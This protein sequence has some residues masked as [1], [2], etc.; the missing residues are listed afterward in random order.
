[1]PAEQVTVEA[2]DGPCFSYVLTPDSG[3]RHP[4]VIMYSD[5]AGMRI[6][7]TEMA[8]QLANAGFIVLVPDPFYRFGPYG[9][10]VPKELFAGDFMAVIGPLMATTGPDKAAADTTS[11]IAYLDTRDDIE[12]KKIGAIGFCMGGG[13][14]IASAGAHPDRIAA[15]ASFHGGNLATDQP[16]SPHLFV[17][18]AK[19]EFYIGAADNDQTY[20]PE[21]AARLEAALT[22]AHVPFTA[23][24]YEGAAHGWMV[25]DFPIYNPT[26]AEKG[27]SKAIALFN[28]TLR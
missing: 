27:W 15:V 10:L 20:P 11:F 28:R 18:T 25:T 17:K 22:E 6:A 7:N 9:P 12:G 2:S 13:M 24:T 21:M 1:M 3:G 5:A 23:E 19:A 4:A 16:N 14:A 26:A 8:Q